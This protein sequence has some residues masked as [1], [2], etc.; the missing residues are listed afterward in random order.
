MNNTQRLKAEHRNDN[1]C[2]CV[3]VCSN[4]FLSNSYFNIQHFSLLACTL[5]A[6]G[7]ESVRSSDYCDSEKPPR[8]FC[9]PKGGHRPITARAAISRAEAINN[10]SRITTALLP[11]FTGHR[12][13]STRSRGAAARDTT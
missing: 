7:E 1:V 8:V 5:A 11:Q 6:Q 13:R 3:C 12:R 9:F 4:H 2:V 10:D